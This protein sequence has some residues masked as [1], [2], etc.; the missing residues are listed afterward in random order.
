MCYRGSRA[1]YTLAL[2]TL[3]L[4]W[5]PWS[6]NGIEFDMV[7]QTK[8]VYEEIVFESSALMTF[9]AF[10]IS[11]PEVK[12]PLNIRVHDQEGTERF[13]KMDQ[14]SDKFNLPGLEEG[15]YKI[16]FTAKSRFLCLHCWFHLLVS[17]CRR[18]KLY[19]PTNPCDDGARRLPYCPEYENQV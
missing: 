17:N 8:C 18:L 7:F 3:L 15:R 9:H 4:L 2:A 11:N 1:G 16:C 12:V 10:Q 5:Q 14:E 13:A 6:V 19:K